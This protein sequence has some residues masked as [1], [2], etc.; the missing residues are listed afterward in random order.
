MGK[1]IGELLVALYE[2]L[3][4]Q[5]IFSMKAKTNHFGNVKFLY[6]SQVYTL[7]ISK[8]IFTFEAII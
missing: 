8:P 6:K 3:I 4:K 7:S 2:N 5:F 1:N